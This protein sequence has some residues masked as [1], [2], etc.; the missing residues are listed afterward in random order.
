M[1]FFMSKILSGGVDENF[2]PTL[3]QFMLI[4]Q[5]GL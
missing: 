2:M 4:D 1:S 5:R 3:N